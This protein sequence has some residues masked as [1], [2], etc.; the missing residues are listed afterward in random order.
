MYDIKIPYFLATKFAS[1]VFLGERGI[2]CKNI[3]NLTM[4]LKAVF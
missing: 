2:S 3:S 1:L 4:L